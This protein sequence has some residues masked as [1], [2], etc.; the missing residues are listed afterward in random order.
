M[1]CKKCG[2]MLDENEVTCVKCGFENSKTTQSVSE[3]GSENSANSALHAEKEKVIGHVYTFRKYF[4]INL[5]CLR[6]GGQKTVGF[7]SDFMQA[8]FRKIPYDTI[9]NI[10]A[11]VKLGI[12]RLIFAA[13]CILLGILLLFD[14]LLP[15]AL[16]II[17]GICVILFNLKIRIVTIQTTQGSCEIHMMPKDSQTNAFMRDLDAMTDHRFTKNIRV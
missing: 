16:C 6:A 12:G 3:D 7:D 15:A 1:L 8:N 11:C 2:T 9:T 4:F 10:A 17:F 13:V 14:F 5:R